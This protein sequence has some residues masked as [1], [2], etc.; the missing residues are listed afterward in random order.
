V[1][2]I[3]LRSPDVS[4]NCLLIEACM[5]LHNIAVRHNDFIEPNPDVVVES[6]A[7]QATDATYTG[8]EHRRQIINNFFT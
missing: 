7:A 1:L 6:Q 2:G 8:K 3:E 4:F 5:V